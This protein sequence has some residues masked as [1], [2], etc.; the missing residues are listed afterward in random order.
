[1]EGTGKGLRAP[2]YRRKKRCI[3]KHVRDTIVRIRGMVEW[4]QF[5]RL[6]VLNKYILGDF[7]SHAGLISRKATL[8][9]RSQAS[10][11]LPQGPRSTK[12]NGNGILSCPELSQYLPS[13][14][15][16]FATTQD[17]LPRHCP[18]PKL[19]GALFSM[20]PL[21][22]MNWQV[23][24]DPPLQRTPW[25]G[26]RKAKCLEPRLSG[27]QVEEPGSPGAKSYR[28][29]PTNTRVGTCPVCSDSLYNQ[30]N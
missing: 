11:S 16:V 10:Q 14:I 3:L 8:C 4:K 6:K 21:E 9:W 15:L 26:L 30:A 28:A 20:T 7:H 19:Q 22:E 23:R 17:T 27:S 12:P 1:M 29:F 5:K 2:G 24:T 25:V 13:Q 18:V